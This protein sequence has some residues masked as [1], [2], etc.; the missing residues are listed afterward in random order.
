MV[1][2]RATGVKFLPFFSSFALGPD[3]QGMTNKNPEDMAGETQDT[4]CLEL[5]SLQLDIKTLRQE[6]EE[7]RKEFYHFTNYVNKNFAS[8]HKNFKKIQSPC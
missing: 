3:L 5:E 6:R 2:F 4:D 1:G 8:I 7:D